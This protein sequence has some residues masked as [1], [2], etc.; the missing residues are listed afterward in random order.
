[1]PSYQIVFNAKFKKQ[2]KK[3][4]ANDKKLVGEILIRLGDGETLEAKY[5]DH[6]L[7]GNLKGLRD[8]HIKPDLLLIYEKKEE[9]LIL[10]ALMV[11]SHSEIFK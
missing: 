7:Q 9:L 3:L 11:S 1:M 2:F 5:K 4:S 10:K 8:C 6:A